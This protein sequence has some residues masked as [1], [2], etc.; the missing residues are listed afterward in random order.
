[1]LQTPKPPTAEMLYA[2]MIA[3]QSVPK[4]G[5]RKSTAKVIWLAMETQRL[6][7]ADALRRALLQARLAANT[8]WDAPGSPLVRVDPSPATP[9]PR[10][11]QHAPWHVA[12]DFGR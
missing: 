6:I 9:A 4:L 11:R 1:M 7:E 10:P 2:G 8:P 5:A 12:G 3:M